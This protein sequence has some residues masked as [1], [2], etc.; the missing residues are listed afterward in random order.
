MKR[1][2]QT[3]KI[4]L[5]SALL[6]SMA[7]Q[8]AVSLDRTRVIVNGGDKATTIGI[9]NDNTEMPYLAQAW[10]AD[11]SGTKIQSPLMVVPPLQRLEAGKNGQVKIQILPAAASLPQDRESLYSFNLREVPP[12]STKPNTLQLALQTTVKLFYRPA[13]IRVDTSAAPFQEKLTLS[14]KGNG[15]VVNNPTPYYITLIAA[16]RS[17]AE[18]YDDFSPVMIAPKSAAELG[19]GTSSLGQNPV[20]TYI[21]DYGGRPQLKFT[22][23]QNLCTAKSAK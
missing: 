4:S 5:L 18:A 22:C 13:A 8:A 10:I 19:A 17:E 21:N 9:R 11:T 6:F 2:Q 15:F 3:L 7:S 12:K 1:H 14:R 16:G 23:A 20:L